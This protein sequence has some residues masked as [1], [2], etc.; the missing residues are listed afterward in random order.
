MRPPVIARA[1]IDDKRHIAP[2]L[3]RPINRIVS[4]QGE[5]LNPL[6][7]DGVNGDV[8]KIAEELEA[9]TAEGRDGHH[10][11]IV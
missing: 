6:D 5:H 8:G 2:R 9:S 10:F 7:I 4:A 3:Q 11:G 1:A